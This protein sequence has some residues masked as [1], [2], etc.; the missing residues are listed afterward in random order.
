MSNLQKSKRFDIIDEFNDTSRYIDDIFTIDNFEFV[1][2]IN[3]LDEATSFLDLGLKLHWLVTG[4]DIRTS[5][6][7]KRDNFEFH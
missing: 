4:S 7:D 2:H 6:N 5:V 3:T 1:K